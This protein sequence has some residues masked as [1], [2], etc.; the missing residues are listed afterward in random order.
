[1]R[2]AFFFSSPK[3]E[4]N[5]NVYQQVSGQRS[6]GTPTCG[7]ITG[8]CK[9]RLLRDTTAAS[10]RSTLLSDSQEPQSTCCKIPSLRSSRNG[11]TL[12][13][14]PCTVAA[15]GRGWEEGMDSKQ[16]Q[17]SFQGVTGLF[18]ILTVLW[19]HGWRCLSKL[20]EM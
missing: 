14:K 15:K 1:M 4:N 7:S 3:T 18:C 6:G 17:G 20:T 13:S 19:L 8:P 10:L 5:P 11:R 16:A 9:S 12:I 2:R